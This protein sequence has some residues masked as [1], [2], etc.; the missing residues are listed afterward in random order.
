MKRI[1][2]IRTE[3]KEYAEELS[4]C[5][6][7][8][9]DWV[10]HSLV[11]TDE[12]AYRA[13]EE[14]NRVDMLLCDEAVIRDLKEPYKAENICI[15]SEFGLALEGA[16]DHPAV[17]KYQAAEQIMKEIVM[18][19]GK[20]QEN[21]AMN[22][23]E[24]E[25][26]RRIFSV[27]SPVGGCHSSTFALALAYYY[28]LGEKTLFISLD[29]FFTLPGEKKTPKEKNLTDILYYLEQSQ[30]RNILAQIRSSTVKK[31]NLECVSG[32]SHWFDLYDMKPAHMSTILDAI[33]SADD[34]VN[35]VF[36]VGVIGAASMEIFLASDSIF[37]PLGT[38]HSSISKLNEWKRQIQ[39]I[40]QAQLLDRIK[41]I[42][43]PHDEILENEYGYDQL[44]KGRV[45]RLIEESEGMQYI[46]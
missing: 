26:R 41:E 38:D 2:A 1:L 33:F 9:S 14:N 17:F 16:G 6:N 37:V 23:P 8:K 13:Y 24:R 34:Y 18:N 5:F 46:R 15:L 39:F 10:F 19:Y 20:R 12:E 43:L 11:F 42:Y 4:R 31:G 30:E 45:G 21:A 44:L 22:P 40:G 7:R 36:D 29:P 27:V 3:E 25:G 32:V 35:I 28:A